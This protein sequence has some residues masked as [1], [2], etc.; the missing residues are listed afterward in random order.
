MVCDSGISWSY[1]LAFCSQF[2]YNLFVFIACTL[3]QHNHPIRQWLVILSLKCLITSRLDR[4]SC[5]LAALCGMI[6][7]L[8]DYY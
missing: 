3:L 7:M 1:S 2:I 8:L 6:V 5:A 4:V